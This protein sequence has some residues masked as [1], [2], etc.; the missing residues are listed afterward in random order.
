VVTGSTLRVMCAR[1]LTEVVNIVAGTFTQGTGI[2]VD[3]DF[4][5]VGVLQAKLDSGV[6]ADVVILSAPVIER[7]VTSGF[8]DAASCQTIGSTGIGVAVREG[9]TKPDIATPDSFKMALT[10]ARSIAFSDPAVGGSAGV[11]LKG[12]F[13]RLGMAD[14]IRTKGLP[15]QSGGEVAR[16]VAEGVAEIGMTQLSEMLVVKGISVVGSLPA[17]LGNDTVYRAAVRTGSA[18]SGAGRTFIAM[19]VAPAAQSLLVAAGFD[20]LRGG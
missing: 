20:P 10:H 9:A 4:G 19:L 1:A 3:I 16:R 17:P 8:A 12:L 2:A 13:E 6:V 15:Q 5:T 11:Y 14:M 18:D 7:L